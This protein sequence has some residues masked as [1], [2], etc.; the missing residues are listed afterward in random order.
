VC[1]SP[2]DAD[3]VSM[4]SAELLTGQDLKAANSFED[5]N[6]VKPIMFEDLTIKQGD[7]TMQLP[8]LS[9]AAVTFKLA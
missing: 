2:A 9:F 5:K 1:L 4:E 8:P 6:V 3:I 7:A